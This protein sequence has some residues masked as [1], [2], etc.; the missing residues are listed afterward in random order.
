MYIWR[1]T[2]NNYPIFNMRVNDSIKVVVKSHI[3]LNKSYFWL[4]F[5][6]VKHDVIISITLINN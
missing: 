5:R 1:T 2:P 3:G 6:K 4:V